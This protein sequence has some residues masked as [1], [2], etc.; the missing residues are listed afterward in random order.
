MQLIIS[1]A[2]PMANNSA[3]NRQINYTMP[4]FPDDFHKLVVG[5]FEYFFFLFFGNTLQLIL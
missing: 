2:I 3:C 1:S 4:I 5:S